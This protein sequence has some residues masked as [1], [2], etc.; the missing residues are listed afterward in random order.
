[1]SPLSPRLYFPPVKITN[2]FAPGKIIVSGEYAVVFGHQGVAVPTT[3]GMLAT[4]EE[5]PGAKSLA[6]HWEGI[7]PTNEWREF[8]DEIIRRIEKHRRPVR[9][10]LTIKNH[11]PLGKGL[12]SSTALIIAVCRSILGTECQ[13]EARSIE[14]VLNPGHSGIDFAVIWEKAP[15]SF[16]KKDGPKPIPLDHSLL[17][18]AVLIDT[19]KPE[20][21]TP[22]LVAWVKSREKECSN[23][24][25]TIGHCSEELMAGK[26]LSE[27]LKKHHRAQVEL[28]IVP[29]KVQKLI[30]E[31]E[32]AGGAAKVVGAGAKSGGGGMVLA[33]GITPVQLRGMHVQSALITL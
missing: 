21:A 23:A 4:Y 2:S 11:L 13:K 1:M 19:G 5:S 18:N 29:K 14:D 25:E 12:G 24:L 10:V 7:Q 33:I 27:I 6:T 32:K 30:S 20:Q 9:G 26:E 3:I 16:T 15:V 22:E 8:L 28:G 31:I 17:A